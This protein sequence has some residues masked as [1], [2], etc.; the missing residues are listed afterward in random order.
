MSLKLT[1]HG[2]ERVFKMGEHGLK[3]PVPS[4]L[5]RTRPHADMKTINEISS[6]IA[7]T[8]KEKAEAAEV[9]EIHGQPS[10]APLGRT[11][12]VE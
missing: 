9:I 12:A 7:K 10:L 1:H 3:I 11:V 2:T 5:T 8:E 4:A 6:N